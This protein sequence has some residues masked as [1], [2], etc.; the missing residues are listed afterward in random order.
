MTKMASPKRSPSPIPKKRPNEESAGLPLSSSSKTTTASKNLEQFSTTKKQKQ[1]H[2][3]NIQNTTSPKSSSNTKMLKGFCTSSNAAKAVVA[4]AL[5]PTQQHTTA[6]TKKH[7]VALIG[8]GNWGSAVATIIGK[9][10]EK[11]PNL[12]EPIINMYVYEEQIEMSKKKLL[13]L[14][15]VPDQPTPSSTVSGNNSPACFVKD[16]VELIKRN[17]SEVINETHVNVKYL[18][19]I[20]LPN[21]I[22]ANNDLKSSCLNAD[23]LIWCVPHQF[24]TRMTGAV[25]ESCAKDAISISLIKGGIDIVDGEIQLCSELIAKE[26]GHECHVL[27]GANL[28]NEVAEGQFCE[29]TIGYPTTGHGHL[30]SELLK[31]LFHLE[32]SFQISTV[33]D[34]PGV[35][36]C[37]A[38]KN[39]VAVGAGFCDGLGLGSNTKAALIRKGLVEMREFVHMF[40]GTDSPST[41][42]E[43]CGVADIITTCFGGRNRKCAEAFAKRFDLTD[44]SNKK[45][46]LWAEIEKELLNGQ[47]LQGTLTSKEIQTVLLKH[48]CVAKFPLFTAINTCAFSE[49]VDVKSFIP[50]LV[51]SSSGALKPSGDSTNTLSST[52]T[53]NSSGSG[54]SISSKST[55]A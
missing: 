17:L 16:G 44:S 46:Q 18:P 40:Y 28:A 13:D 36:L 7:K 55:G 6:A 22:Y 9:N 33:P 47:K 27:M 25:K 39:I 45:D 21:S 12:F 14:L 30:T 19:D 11:H 10:V 32:E 52:A 34:V 54:A 42:F 5:V 4:P 15:P 43:S 26:M 24:V 23:I 37:G 8:S 38:L 48:D 1:D 20:R 35:E 51:G 31:Q 53:M 50:L 29:A 49:G 3:E 2:S 41:F